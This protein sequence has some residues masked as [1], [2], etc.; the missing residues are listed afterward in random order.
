MKKVIYLMIMLMVGFGFFGVVN[1]AEEQPDNDGVID[2]S[3]DAAEADAEDD[4]NGEVEDI[5]AEAEDENDV[6]D[7]TEDSE[8]PDTGLNDYVIYALPVLLIGGSVL[9]L[10]RNSFN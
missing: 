1:A 8:N 7:A 6:E 3:D 9:V 10:K 5:D 4:E 2:V